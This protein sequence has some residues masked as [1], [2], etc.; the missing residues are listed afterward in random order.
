MIDEPECYTFKFIFIGDTGVGKSCMI[1]RMKD[2]IFQPVHEPTIGVTFIN[3][4]L[5]IGTTNLKMQLWDT[6]GQEIFRS[7]TRSYYRESDCAI[8]VYDVSN[9][10]SYNCLNLWINDVREFAPKDCK[11]AIVGNKIDLI[12]DRKIKEEDALEFVSTHK[13]DYFKETS[14][15]TG[16]NITELIEEL[17]MIVYSKEMEQNGIANKDSLTIKDQTLSSE[18]KKKNCC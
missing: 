1:L 14:A 5:N 15:L 16:E 9:P 8:I 11:I 4:M 18:E 3:Q 10:C 6:A 7:I 2:G 12:D 13:I 17:A